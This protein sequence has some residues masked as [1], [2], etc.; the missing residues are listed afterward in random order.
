MP[1][2]TASGRVATTTRIGL[3][4]QGSSYL[5][6]GINAR[7]AIAS[8]VGVSGLTSTICIGGWFKSSFHKNTTGGANFPAPFVIGAGPF[9]YQNL[10]NANTKFN[11]HLTI[12][13]VLQDGKGGISGNGMVPNTWFHYAFDYDGATL[14]SYLNGVQ[15]SAPFAVTGAI[16]LTDSSIVVG[17]QG[18]TSNAFWGNICQFFVGS[19]LTATQIAS[20]A[21]NNIYPSGLVGLYPM[22]EGS[23]G[24][25]NDISGNGNNLTITNGSWSTD[26]PSKIRVASSGRTQAI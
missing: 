4:N 2:G 22:N 18:G 6:N 3:F 5:F 25:F 16:T 8:A 7:G 9:T 19:H 12:G 24:T 15:T 11:S 14:T 20:I 23:G 17:S 1:R 26:V 21:R 10:P 13:G